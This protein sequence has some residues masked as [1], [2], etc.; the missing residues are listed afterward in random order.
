MIPKIAKKNIVHK[1]SKTST[2]ADFLETGLALDLSRLQ[3]S[4]KSEIFTWN[5]IKNEQGIVIY[6]CDQNT[7]KSEGSHL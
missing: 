7:C 1:V 6:E 2:D 5:D 3:R 4:D